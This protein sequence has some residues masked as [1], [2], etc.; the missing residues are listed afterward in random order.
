M[1]VF[2]SV[3]VVVVVTRG[4]RA[5]GAEGR[6]ARA[7]A[8]VLGVKGIHDDGLRALDF[9]AAERAAR[10]LALRLLPRKKRQKGIQLSSRFYL[11]GGAV[12]RGLQL[13]NIF[14]AFQRETFRGLK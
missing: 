13:T 14:A 8:V 7:P 11:Q 1:G 5:L 12:Q 9:T 2:Q 3:V 6:P 10:P 4:G